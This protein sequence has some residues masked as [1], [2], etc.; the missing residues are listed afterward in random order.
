MSITPSLGSHIQQRV[1]VGTV[2]ARPPPPNSGQLR[3]VVLVAEF[4]MGVAEA[5]VGP[6]S[7]LYPMLFPSVPSHIGLNLEMVPQQTSRVLIFISDS[8]YVAV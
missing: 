6:A 2:N 7:F 5:S 1:H 4:P 3:K 8:A